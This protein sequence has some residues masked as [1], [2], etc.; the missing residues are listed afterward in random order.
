QVAGGSTND[1]VALGVESVELRALRDAERE[2]FP[3]SAPPPGTPWPGELPSPIASSPDQPRVHAS[4]LPPAPV[5]SSPPAAEGG[6]DLSWMS[7]LQLPELPVR[8]EPRL[9]RYLEFF[10]DDPRGRSLLTVWLRRS[11]RYREAIRRTL[12]KK[13]MPE[14]LLWLAMTESGFDAGARS[15]VGALGLWQF[16]PDTGRQYGLGQDR[17]ID[18]R[19]SAQAATEAACEFL[20]DLHRRFGSWELAIAAYNMGY[21]GILSVVRKYNTNDFWA[22]SRMEGALP[23]ETTLYVPKIIAASI[24]ARNL[25]VFGFADLA[26]EPAVEGDEVVVPPGTSLASV[27]QAAGATTKEIEALNLELR[28]SRTPPADP[29]TAA[30][31]PASMYPVKVP[32]GKGAQA[33][34]GLAKLRRDQAPLERYVVRFGE[35]LE[36][37]A[38]ARSVSVARLIEVNGITQGEV[39]RGGTV[40]LMPKGASP[41]SPTSPTSP[42]GTAPS[43]APVVIVPSDLFVYPDR[44]RVFY[45]VVTGDTLRDVAL[46]FKVSVDELRRWNE[47]DP[48]GRLVEGMTLQIFVP[49]GADLTK[50]VALNEADVRPL[51]VGSEDFFTYWEALKNKKRIAL[52]AKAG[53]TLDLIGRRYGVTPG[54]MERINHRGR[55]EKLAE[56]DP[57][58]VYVPF[59]T[60][61]PAHGAASLSTSLDNG[62][63]PLGP[64]P[65]APA[66]DNLPRTN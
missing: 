38:S 32:L 14:D 34:Q 25:A 28:A 36:Q 44:R 58:V 18:Y 37:I 53:D 65:A 39:V 8:W 1:D 60:P 51:A 24:V 2:L 56:G 59:A 10:K 42:A 52:T 4:G 15:P 17:W 47:I 12:R 61:A 31:D 3:T 66:P 21:T 63:D 22:L 40:L 64:L 16:M 46:A 23:F 29:G 50:V 55:N 35:T 33:T 27:A 62:P 6:K 54:W 48:A 20:A 19:L 9:V 43:T 45:R 13:G 26:V 11:G 41:T 7:R 57:V 5:P 49:Q 30:G